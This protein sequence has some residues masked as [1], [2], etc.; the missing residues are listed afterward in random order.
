MTKP[1]LGFWKNLPRPI[2]GLAP[3]D[4]VTDVV[5]RTMVARHG[6]PDVVFTE[7][8]HV[9]GLIRASQRLLQDFEYTDQERP[10]VAQIYGHRPEFFYL[11][12]HVVCEL[13]FDGVDIN[14]GC[15]AKKVVSKNCGAGLIREPTLA[16]EI[17]RQ[18]KQAILDWADGQKLE[19]LDIPNKLIR[20]VREANARRGVSAYARRQIPYSVKTRLGYDSCIVEGW[21]RTLLAEK[22]AVITLHGRTLKQMYKGEADWEAIKRATQLIHETDTLAF[23]NGDITSL[24]SAAER[25]TESGVDGVLLGRASIGMPWIFQNKDELR[26]VVSGESPGPVPE[27]FQSPMQRLEISLEHAALLQELRGERIFP[28]LK[29]HLSAY[30]SGFPGAAVLRRQAMLTKNFSELRAQLE[31]YTQWSFRGNA[32]ARKVSFSSNY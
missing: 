16:R 30:L 26:R 10:V 17:I 6:K 1:F 9:E 2:V 8:T 7:F 21:V 28:A 12:T 24:Q 25:I 11:A 20:L 19:S 18:T 23:G 29:R 27:P 4:G 14:M 3:M 13:G 15:P 31:P 5:C 22:P 32:E